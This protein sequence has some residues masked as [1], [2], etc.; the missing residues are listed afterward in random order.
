MCV[1]VRARTCVG[2]GILKSG[3]LDLPYSSVHA[4]TFDLGYN[5]CKVALKQP[6]AVQNLLH[7]TA[8]LLFT[9]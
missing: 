3:F 4:L 1:C 9:S 8:S 6:A 7:K 5:N 2:R